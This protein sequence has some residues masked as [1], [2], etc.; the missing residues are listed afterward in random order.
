MLGIG[1]TSRN[2]VTIAVNITFQV[3]TMYFFHLKKHTVS[4]DSGDAAMATA[5]WGKINSLI[6]SLSSCNKAGGCMLDWKF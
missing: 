3:D 4:D 1:R 2:N 5:D 6:E